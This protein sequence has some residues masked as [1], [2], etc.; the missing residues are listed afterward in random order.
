[1]NLEALKAWR[2][3]H[4]YLLGLVVL[5]EIIWILYGGPLP[6]WKPSEVTAA[7][8]GLGAGEGILLFAVLLLAG[9][10]GGTFCELLVGFV[11]IVRNVMAAIRKRLWTNHASIIRL[12]A[13]ANLVLPVEELSIQ[14]LQSNLEFF[15]EHLSLF[16]TGNS[17]PEDIEKVKEHEKEHLARV[18]AL[19]LNPPDPRVWIW[20][21]YSQQLTQERRELDNLRIEEEIVIFAL[22]AGILAL[23]LISLFVQ[24]STFVA[25][26]ILGVLCLLGGITRISRLRFRS[27]AYFAGLVLMS[28]A[29]TEGADVTDL[30]AS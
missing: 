20:V 27:A 24:Q 25:L 10:I 12:I 18:R 17:G 1:M 13:P 7:L 29:L 8:S 28:Y 5:V 30:D 21:I 26:L 23:V 19:L 3:L 9:I 16:H 6:S 15:L 11:D 4:R 2:Y 22:M 14:L